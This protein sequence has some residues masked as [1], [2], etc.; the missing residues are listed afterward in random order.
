MSRLD[1]AA[2]LVEYDSLAELQ[3]H[4]TSKNVTTAEEAFQCV[5]CFGILDPDFIAEVSASVAESLEKMPYDANTFILALNLPTSQTL[6]ESLISKLRTDFRGILIQV[7]FKVRNVDAYIKK[8]WRGLEQ[9]PNTLLGPPA[10]FPGNFQERKKR[11]FGEDSG[12]SSSECSKQQLQ[13]VLNRISPEI[14]RKY[15]YKSPTKKCTYKLEFERDPIYIAGRYCKFSRSL[16]QSPWSEEKDAPREP[17][18]SVSEKVCD[19]LKTEFGASDSRFITSGR[20]DID[21]RMLGEGRPFVVELRNCKTTKPLQGTR[22]LETLPIVEA[23]INGQLDIKVKYLTRVQRDVAEKL[24]VGEEEKRK[25]YTAYCYSSLPLA[26]ESFEKAFA[27]IPV[28]VINS[29]HC[30]CLPRSLL[31]RPRS[32]YTMEFLPLDKHHFLTRVET[33]AGTYIKEFVHGDF[34][35]TRPS[36]ADLLGVEQGEVD[37]LELDV[38][39]VDHP[40]PPKYEKPVHFR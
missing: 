30:S 29:Q 5:L 1:S 11:R 20:E 40:W 10:N 27:A 38:E 33:Q 39:K 8:N 21:V 6:R 3:I 28:E 25:Q 37:I 31:D 22:Y 2:V 15:S 32:V 19:V 14:A 36:L 35:R 9:T 34:G 16:P 7:P 12:P 17:G 26:P 23:K 24:S 4:K 13:Q 18:N